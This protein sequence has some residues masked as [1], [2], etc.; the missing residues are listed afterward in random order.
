MPLTG[1]SGIPSESHSL[2]QARV[3]RTRHAGPMP[4]EELAAALTPL[5]SYTDVTTAQVL[6]AVLAAYNQARGEQLTA[7]TL[8][9]DAAARLRLYL[10]EAEMSGEGPTLFHR[11]RRLGHLPPYPDTACKQSVLLQRGCDACP[12]GNEF[13]VTSS[14][15]RITTAA[16]DYRDRSAPHQRPPRRP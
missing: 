1:T 7:A 4:Y 13:P 9:K 2:E 6:D 14:P 15:A 10:V 11:P 5:L 16:R 3:T 12:D 8:D